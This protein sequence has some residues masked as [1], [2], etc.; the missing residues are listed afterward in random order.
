MGN[1]SGVTATIFFYIQQNVK[2]GHRA[3]SCCYICPDNQ[4]PFLAIPHMQ[5]T[6]TKALANSMSTQVLFLQGSHFIPFS[7]GKKSLCAAPPI[8]HSH[9]HKQ[10]HNHLRAHKPVTQSNR[11]PHT[12]LQNAFNAQPN[13][14][15]FTHTSASYMQRRT[16]VSTFP[17]NTQM[18][19][20]ARAH[21]AYHLH[22]HVHDVLSTQFAKFHSFLYPL[23]CTR[24]CAHTRPMPT[25]PANSAIHTLTKP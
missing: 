14:N 19:A 21:Y 17:L 13:C 16:L 4:H 22:D 3:N 6:T 9:Q 24:V 15:I 23:C 5:C 20:R 25:E 11:Y 8:H 7:K 1:F 10:M 12:H 18:C 2:W